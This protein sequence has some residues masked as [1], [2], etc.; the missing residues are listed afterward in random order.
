MEPKQHRFIP[1]RLA[2]A[3]GAR[4]VEEIAAVAGVTHQTVRNWEAGKGE[5]NLSQIAAIAN[6]TGHP[7]DFFLGRGRAA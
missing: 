2:K 3:R 4:R 7:I 6:L 1:T 5:P